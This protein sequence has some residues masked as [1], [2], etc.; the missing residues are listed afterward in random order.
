MASIS[1]REVERTGRPRPNEAPLLEAPQRD[2]VF[3]SSFRVRYSA[4][5]LGD[6][7][8]ERK[9]GMWGTKE[10][11]APVARNGTLPRDAVPSGRPV[12]AMQSSFY[13]ST[14]G[15]CLFHCFF[16]R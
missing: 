5:N 2:I 15:D 14:Q 11:A 10:R 8:E 7:E 4:G 12:R 6:N 3:S 1:Q 16:I 9:S 13:L